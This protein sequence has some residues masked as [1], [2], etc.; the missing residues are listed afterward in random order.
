MVPNYTVKYRRVGTFL[1]NS[2]SANLTS[3]DSFRVARQPPGTVGDGNR[4]SVRNFVVSMC[5]GIRDYF[6]HI[7]PYP[8]WCERRSLQPGTP[9]ELSRCSKYYRPKNHLRDERLRAG[10]GATCFQRRMTSL[11]MRCQWSWITVRCITNCISLMAKLASSQR[12]R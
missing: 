4:L 12:L 8:G 7:G 1:A 9:A 5:A 3:P 11:I 6:V 2:L 10:T